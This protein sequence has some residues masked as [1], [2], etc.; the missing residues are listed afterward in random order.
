MYSALIDAWI[1][2]KDEGSLE[3]AFGI[4]SDLNTKFKNGS[5]HVKPSTF[6]ANQVIDAYSKS[7]KPDAGEH[8]EEIL[9]LLE[10]L[11]TRYQDKDMKPNV[12]TYTITMNA[13]A[14]SR[15]FGK[16]KRAYTLLA[17]MEKAYKEGNHDVKPNVF[18]YTA[19]VSYYKSMLRCNEINKME[20]KQN[21][22]G[23][24][25]SFF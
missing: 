10:S 17:Q 18:A 8:A 25:S 5:G 6:L 13:W 4:F 2:S 19:V 11:Y 23:F 9:G 1:K 22:H 14:K 12:Q 15:S 21:I 3:R 7:G 24:F 16:A 20:T